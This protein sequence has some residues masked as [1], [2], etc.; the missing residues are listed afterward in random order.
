M[1]SNSVVFSKKI[2]DLVDTGK[3]DLVTSI[4]SGNENT[5][6]NIRGKNKFFDV[7]KNL[8][9]YSQFKPE[10]VVIKFIF[11]EGNLDLKEVV[12]FANEIKKRGL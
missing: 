7:F 10:N 11:T 4:D 5:F 8:S 9:K 6:L 12:E 2:Q 3:I 1:L